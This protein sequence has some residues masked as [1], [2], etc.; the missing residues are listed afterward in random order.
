M[1]EDDGL[2]KM[3]VAFQL[4]LRDAKLGDERQELKVA[5]LGVAHARRN[6]IQKGWDIG[7]GPLPNRR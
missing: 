1:V 7:L 3:M 5:S 4:A 2:A 6:L